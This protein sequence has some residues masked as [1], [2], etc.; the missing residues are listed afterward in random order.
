M[1]NLAMIATLVLFGGHTPLPEL[2]MTL[3]WGSVAGSA[4]QFVVQVPVVLQVAKDLR[5]S[6][7]VASEHVRIVT[8]NFVPV[9]VSRGVVQV[10]AYVD[11]M[12]A[13]FLPTGALTGLQ[14]ATLLY[15]LPVSLFGMSVA[16][17]ELPTMSG[18]ATLD[19][20]GLQALRA[21]L[22]KGLRRIAFFV[23]PSAMAFLALGDVVA[24]ALLQTGRFTHDDAVRVWAILAGSAVGGPGSTLGRRLSVT[25]SS[26]R[27]TQQRS[28]RSRGPLGAG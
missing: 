14:N 17:A 11:A 22:D 2:A 5:F 10:S 19:R 23:V 7:G 25:P 18:V 13:S 24:A 1:W 28:R 16:A 6:I 26:P 3:A 21:R 12:L 20:E 27:A 15:T 8:R 9:F 4:L